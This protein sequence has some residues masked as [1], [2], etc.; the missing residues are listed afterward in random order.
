MS[1]FDNHFYNPDYFNPTYYQQVK[2]TID[3]SLY[4]I[5]QDQRVLTAL[6][7]FQD[8][9]D[10]VE[11]MDGAH[12]ERLFGLCLAEMAKRRRWG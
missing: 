9:L 7:D 1:Y 6:H 11:G 4:S 3:S 5:D 2:N 10:Q 8:M 12:Q